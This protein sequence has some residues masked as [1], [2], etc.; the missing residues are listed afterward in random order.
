MPEVIKL[1]REKVL[2]VSVYGW[3]LLLSTPHGGMKVE[4]LEHA[5]GYSFTHGQ[6]QKG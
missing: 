1:R 2:W 5:R 3:P 4:S 6:E